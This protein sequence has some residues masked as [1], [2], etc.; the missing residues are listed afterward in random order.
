MALISR[1]EMKP[2]KDTKGAK[3]RNCRIIM[4]ELLGMNRGIEEEED[5]EAEASN[6]RLASMIDLRRGGG[7]Y[8]PSRAR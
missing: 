5:E 7:C 2:Q 6:P 1:I 8:G 4:A 3:A